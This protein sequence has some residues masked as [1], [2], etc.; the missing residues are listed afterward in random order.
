[1]RVTV[2]GEEYILKF[3]FYALIRHYDRGLFDCFRQNGIF[4]VVRKFI[5]CFLHLSTDTS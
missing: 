4:I 3:V 1:M 5:T 2:L